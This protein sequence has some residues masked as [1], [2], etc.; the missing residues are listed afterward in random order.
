MA[1]T[2]PKLGPNPIVKHLVLS[3]GSVNGL[4]MYGAL[5]H[6]NESGLWQHETLESIWAT[7]VGAILATMVALQFDWTT[8]DAYIVNR[9]WEDVFQIT[10]EMLFNS[11][12]KK[13]M[14]D[15]SIIR[16]IFKPLLLA[17]GLDLDITFAQLYAVYPVELHFFSFDLNAFSTVEISRRTYPNLSVITGIAM[18]CALPGAFAPVFLPDDDDNKHKCFIDGGVRCNYPLLPCLKA[19][20]NKDQVLGITVEKNNVLTEKNNVLTE[21]RGAVNAES[22]ILDF[23]TEFASKISGFLDGLEANPSILHEVRCSS[24]VNVF[25]WATFME[26]IKSADMRKQWIQQGSDDAEKQIKN[27][28]YTV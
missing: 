24:R 3:G 26:V 21:K 14:F 18:S 12:S 23:F 4:F 19:H 13:G 25:E 7:S 20:P 28:D 9:P 8:L 11:Y 27:V 6:C 2:E 17:K 10:G 1:E 16:E 15:V 5:K 22:N